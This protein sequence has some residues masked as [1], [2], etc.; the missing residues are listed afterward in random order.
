MLASVQSDGFILGIRS[1]R[2]TASLE[3]SAAEPVGLVKDV[4][5]KFHLSPC[6]LAGNPKQLLLWGPNQDWL[7]KVWGQRQDEKAEFIVYELLRN[8]R[9]Q[10]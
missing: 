9:Q 3:N 2:D 1:P 5:G 4:P 10:E 7:H 8:L 6:L